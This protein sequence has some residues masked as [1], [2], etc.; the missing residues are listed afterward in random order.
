MEPFRGLTT[1]KMKGGGVRCCACQA[2]GMWW[3]L[4]EGLVHCS[5]SWLFEC[6]PEADPGLAGEIDYISHLAWEC[7]RVHPEKLESMAG[8]RKARGDFLSLLPPWTQLGKANWCGKKWFVG[9]KIIR[10][11]CSEIVFIANCSWYLN[12]LNK[13]FCFAKVNKE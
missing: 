4:L 12:M 1:Y 11:H 9:E 6:G 2:A 5:G 7:L 13:N 8:D 10:A 3:R